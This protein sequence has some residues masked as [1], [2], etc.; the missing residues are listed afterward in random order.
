MVLRGGGAWAIS[1]LLHSLAILLAGF[2]LLQEPAPDRPVL[3]MRFLSS[4]LPP[5]VGESSPATMRPPKAAFAETPGTP[6][7]PTW[8]DTPAPPDSEPSSIPVPVLLEELIGTSRS[9][10]PE[11]TAVATAS[12]WGGP[13]GLGYA[14]PPLPPPSLTPP[15]GAQWSLLLSVPAGGGFARSVEGLD[16]GNPDLDRWLEEYLRTVS[17]PASPDG[18]DYE[19]RWNL[20]L[21][22]E[23]PQ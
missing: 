6:S 19:V 1:A 22:S 18:Q 20:R 4:G 5:S 10:G 14:P 11:P 12:R 21:G 3:R 8:H 15:Q 17:F 13:E 16:S 23:R 7:L 2:F 9:P